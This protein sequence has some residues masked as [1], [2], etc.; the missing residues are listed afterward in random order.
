MLKP[1]DEVIIFRT[2]EELIDL[3]SKCDIMVKGSD[4]IG[5]SVIGETYCKRVV[6]YDRIDE[7]STTKK[8]Q[9]IIT[10]R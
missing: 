7:Y 10:R 3:V 1:V 4:Y 9:D 2:K 6:Y 5:K 8:I